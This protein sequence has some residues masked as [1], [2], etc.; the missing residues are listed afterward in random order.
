MSH[1]KNLRMGQR[2]TNK[3]L[4]SEIK[5]LQKRCNLVSFCFGD[6]IVYWMASDRMPGDSRPGSGSNQTGNSTPRRIS[7]RRCLG[8]EG[9]RLHAA[10][11]SLVIDTHTVQG[12]ETISSVNVLTLTKRSP[13]L[14]QCLFQWLISRTLGALKRCYCE[15]SRYF[16]LDVNIYL[17]PC[18]I[19][20]N[21]CLCG[22]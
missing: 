8:I 15:C 5:W 3:Y 11:G 4:F 2:F 19:Y 17:T 1:A 10:R 13:V 7:T 16:V 18:R 22:M 14:M 21:K 12:R 20:I 6:L 9:Y